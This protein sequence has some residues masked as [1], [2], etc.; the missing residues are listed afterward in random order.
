MSNTVK[1]LSERDSNQTN[2]SSYN[3]VDASFSTA[4]FLVGKA[5]REIRPTVMTTTILND[6]VE[7]SYLE[8]SV[9]LYAIKCVY[10]TGART[11]L[12]SAKRVR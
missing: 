2:Q 11:D 9:E 5:G 1:R 8:D 10:T 6:S 7:Y 12:I 4:G 3:D